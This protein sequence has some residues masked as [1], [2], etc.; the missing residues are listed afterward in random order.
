LRIKEYLSIFGTLLEKRRIAKAPKGHNILRLKTYK[1]NM[2][3]TRKYLY[4]LAICVLCN[5]VLKAQ[6]SYKDDPVAMVL[7]SLLQLNIFEKHTKPYAKN[8]KYNFAPDSIPVYDEATIAARLAKLD[9]QSPFDLVYNKDVDRYIDMYL[10]KRQHMSR[11]LGLSQLYFPMFEQ[12]LDKYNLPLELKYLAVVESALNPTIRSRAGAVGLWQFIYPTGKMYN[13]KMTSYIDERCDPLKE[14]KAACEFLQFLYETYG[15]WQVALAA[16]NCG[17]GNVN[18][19]IRRSGG[20][21]TYWEIRPYLPK[22]TQGYVPCFIAVNYVMAYAAEHNLYETVP[23]K[24]FYQVDTVTIKAQLTFKQIASMLDMTVEEI[25]YLNPIY[26][27]NVIPYDS[28]NTYSLCLPLSKI[29]TFVSNEKAIYDQLKK[30]SSIFITKEVPK[31]VYV[32]KGE[33]L[34]TIAN[35]YKCTVADII[36]W[37]NLKSYKVYG[38]QKLTV[39]IPANTEVNEPKNTTVKNTTVK[40]P[41]KTTPTS[42]D[43]TKTIASNQEGKYKY[44]TIKNGDNL[45]NLAQ[46]Y[47]TTVEELKKLNGYSGKY[48]LHTGQKVIVGTQKN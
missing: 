10:G 39:Y 18:K 11:M 3:G 43:K 31:I 5:G 13:L 41:P 14:T 4:L 44:H 34:N 7:D 32:K 35:R 8:S 12:E 40:T 33:H 45:W 27:R 23:K 30:D 29:G 46:Q 48:M 36:A 2:S 9:A 21:K 16:Y 22:E 47:G 6:N 38:G 17:P 20:K 28:T 42:T 26:R 25:E 24:T 15:D 19:A 1:M 37:N